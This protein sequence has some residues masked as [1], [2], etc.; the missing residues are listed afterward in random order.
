M[1]A[2]IKLS[3]YLCVPRMARASVG[4]GHGGEDVR[5]AIC[6]KSLLAHGISVGPD[7]T[8]KRSLREQYE[9]GTEGLRVQL[10]L[11]G[12]SG[13]VSAVPDEAGILRVGQSLLFRSTVLVPREAMEDASMC[14][15]Q[16]GEREIKAV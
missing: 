8:P 5:L 15:Q 9:R 12:E 4:S 13:Q 3:A 2:T 11:E 10:V 6:G 1:A 7:R 14:N 16:W